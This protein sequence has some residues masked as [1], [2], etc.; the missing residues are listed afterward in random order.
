MIDEE[1]SWPEALGRLQAAGFRTAAGTIRHTLPGGEPGE[2]RFWHE[3]PDRWR[4]EDEQGV[5]HLA[6]GRRELV[7]TGDGMED[8]S[9]AAMRHGL[10]HPQGL[11]GVRAGR[12]TVEFDWLR[13]FPV[14]DGPGVAVEVAG[15]RAWEFT[16]PAAEAKRA[17]KPYPLRV[18]VDEATGTVLRLAIP[19]AGYVVELTEFTV[20]GAPPSFAWDGP[21]STRHADERAAAERVRHWLAEAA[22]PMPHWWPHG[23]AH[24]GG[25]GDP[26][27]GA[28]RVLLEVPGHPE[29]SRWPAGTPMPGTWAGRHPGRHVHR[30]SDARWEWALAVDRPLTEPDLARVIESIPA[31]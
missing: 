28:Y 16:L 27:T 2:L 17:R 13:D 20:D 30:W 26:A 10:P 31:D 4:V 22:L 9:L 5:R 21:V 12:G 18:A 11:F 29:L 3:V 15:R 8:F 24:H 19:E 23:L 7:R 25:D 1:P 14:P 6:D